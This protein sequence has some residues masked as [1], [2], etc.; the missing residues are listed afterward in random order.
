M[1]KIKLKKPVFIVLVVLLFLFCSLGLYRFG[2]HKVSNDTN[3]VTF[4]VREGISK[5]QIVDDLKSAGL[6]RSKIST[7]VYLT[8][9]K[10]MTLQAGEYSFS[11]NMDTPS[12]LAKINKGDIATGTVT[13]TFLEG[14]NINDFIALISSKLEIPESEVKAVFQDKEFMRS[15]VEKY[16]FLTETILN[17]NMYYAL[18]GYLYPDTYEFLE[19]VSVKDIIL[20]MLENTKIKLASFEN[21][22]NYSIHELLTMASIVELEAVNESDRRTVA[23]VIYKRLKMGKGLGMDVTTY[24]AVQKKLGEELTLSDLR[25]ASL[26]NTSEMNTNMAG[27]LPIGP[28]CN[29]S[30]QSILAVLNPSDTDYLFFYADVKTGKVYF[31]NT[32]EEH[33][34]IQKEIG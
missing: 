8:L 4:Q 29:P 10:N 30:L 23:Q 7:L 28:I 33:I 9:H 12:I 20:R 1:K 11:R 2:L 15:L 31:S 34:Q 22:T 26:Y 5:I 19:T 6:I 24:Y 32:I 18:E 16:D 17:D 3:S 27:K 13:L 25:S 21:N 14:K